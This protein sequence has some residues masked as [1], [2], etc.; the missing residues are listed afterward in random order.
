MGTSRRRRV[1]RSRVLATIRVVLVLVLL[2]AIA[3]LAYSVGYWDG[4]NDVMDLGT[5]RRFL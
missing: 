1:T 2:T 3:V 4:W 5:P